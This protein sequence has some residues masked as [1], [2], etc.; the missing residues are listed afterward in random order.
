MI[1]EKLL[2][3]LDI[4][5]TATL[6]LE[7]GFVLNPRVEAEIIVGE[8][9]GLARAELYLN[10]DGTLTASEA[11][12]IEKILT[13]RLSGKPLQYIL[14][15]QQ[16][17]YLDIKCAEGVLIPRPETE[18][19]VEVA[20]GELENLGGA[21]SVLDIGTGS[22]AIALSIA[23]EYEDACVCAVDISTRAL[24]LARDNVVLN[25]LA[26]RVEVIESDLFSGVAHLKGTLDMVVSNPPYIPCSEIASLQ[27]E[28]TFEPRS[29]LDG[30][31]DGLAFYRKIVYGSPEFLKQGGFLLFEVGIN[32]SEPVRELIEDTGWFAD[33]D[34]LCDY[35]GIERI[36][37]ARRA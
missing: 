8:V 37:K 28:V 34:V 35:Q 7:G 13:D 1:A 10:R 23:Y 20:L 17:R 11:S 6:Q 12:S 24:A 26:D 15:H 32:Q 31:E 29:A 2:R 18:L 3:V 27:R 4:L 19:L 16:F 5:N 33:T 21:R 25:G 14:G 22:G 30:G 36:V 9:L